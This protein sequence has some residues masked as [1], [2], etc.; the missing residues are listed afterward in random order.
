MS[1]PTRGGR[2]SFRGADRGYGRGLHRNLTLNNTINN[3]QPSV[4]AVSED[5]LMQDVPA[6]SGDG[7][8]APAKP[9]PEAG[10]GSPMGPPTRPGLQPLTG[11]FKSFS[12]NLTK[13]KNPI[14]N[15]P[16]RRPSLPSQ[17]EARGEDRREITNKIVENVKSRSIQKAEPPA[18]PP[19]PKPKPPASHY[20]RIA[21]V[22]EGTYG[23]V[24]KAKNVFTGELVALKRLR[25]EG[26]RDGF[27]I[28]AVREMKLLQ[29]LRHPHIVAFHETMVENNNCYM[30]FEYIDHDLTGILKH[31]TFRLPPGQIKHLARQFFDGLFY[32]HHRGVLHRDLKASNILVSS[33]GVLK[34]ADFGLARPYS[35]SKKGLDYTN[36]IITLWYRPPEVLL[37]AT[38]YGP[39]VDIWSAGCVFIEFFTQKAIFQ[40]RTDIDQLD[41]VYN[42]LGTPNK[43]EWPGLVELPWYSLLRKPKTLPSRFRQEYGSYLTPAAL[44]L[45]ELCF[46]FDPEKRPTAE[47]VLKHTYFTEEEP[48]P[49]EPIGLRDLVGDWHE[50]EAKAREKKE[51]DG[52][53]E[54]ER[55]E[56][57][58]RADKAKEG[59]GSAPAVAPVA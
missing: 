27:P 10:S 12:L 37:G 16:P 41:A 19:K 43:D 56:R 18:P 11:P 51:R 31:K 42:I 24:Y 23:K 3:H 28:T 45:L 36:R 46:Q 39:A 38:A 33:S 54:K 20:E 17:H 32:L 44:E 25:M 13:S 4:T 58:E 9:T 55:A 47:E 48:M 50:F 26:E 59:Q 29:S 21:M 7:L 30:V 14:R 52:K 15:E 35:K 8:N 34:I 1:I 5:V 2:G 53:R 57:A 40:G 22:G 6:N 49:E